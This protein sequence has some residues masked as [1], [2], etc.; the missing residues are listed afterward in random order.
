MRTLLILA[1]ASLAAAGATAQT[2]PAPCAAAPQYN[3]LDFM[4]GDWDIV[5]GGRPVAWITLEKDGRNCLIREQY[6][7]PVNGGEGAGVDYWDPHAGI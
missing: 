2:A 6:G 4:L 5:V 7:V 1:W 3:A